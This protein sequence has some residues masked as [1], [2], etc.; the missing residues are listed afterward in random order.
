MVLGECSSHGK[1][2]NGLCVCDQ[3]WTGIG[4]FSLI[5][6]NCFVN[7]Q[8]VLI[9]SGSSLALG[10]ISLLM[11][12]WLVAT[13]IP[14][15]LYWNF[16]FTFA[17]LYFINSLV[18]DLYNIIWITS[19]SNATI[20]SSVYATVLM[21]IGFFTAYTGLVVF[22]NS[23][24]V[25]LRG[26]YKIMSKDSRNVLKLSYETFK[27]RSNVLY[28]CSGFCSFICFASFLVPT[29][30]VIIVGKVFYGSFLS[31]H[32]LYWF[33]LNPCINVIRNELLKFIETLRTEVPDLWSINSALISKIT[34]N[35]G[36]LQTV[37]NLTNY[38]TTIIYVVFI[39]WDEFSRGFV[40]L[41]IIATVLVHFSSFP[42]VYIILARNNPFKISPQP[43][44]TSEMISSIN[45][46]INIPV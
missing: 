5:Q 40:Y 12:G 42:M 17:L 29:D 38:L 46:N 27:T 10:L 36:I 14:R 43:L 18:C 37:L 45:H 25:L 32:C 33:T 26:T 35:L 20:G 23:I 15:S 31:F 24:L 39:A 44:P 7:T 13:R 6:D 16:Q 11:F 41:N 22:M 19:G 28:V 9:L 4:D 34:Y 21:A 30:K 8:L 2:L 3:G 1:M